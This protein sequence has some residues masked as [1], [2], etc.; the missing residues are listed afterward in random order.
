[1]VYLAI[2]TLI[3]TYFQIKAVLNNVTMQMTLPYFF[4][5]TVKKI[6]NLNATCEDDWVIFFSTVKK[7]Y[8]LNVT[9]RDIDFFSNC[10]FN[11]TTALVSLERGRLCVKCI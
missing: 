6:Y 10:Y 7:I 8:N 3:N 2:G 4:F 11:A 5:S 1:M 9:C